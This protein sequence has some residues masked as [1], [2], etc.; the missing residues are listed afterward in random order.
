[1]LG[2]YRSGTRRGGN[3]GDRCQASSRQTPTIAKGGQAMKRLTGLMLEALQS[4]SALLALQ[5]GYGVPYFFQ[6]KL[7]K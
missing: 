5:D 2:C 3:Q 1:M 6:C 4:M 7:G